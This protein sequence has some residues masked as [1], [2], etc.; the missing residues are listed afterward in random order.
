MGNGFRLGWS[1]S[2]ASRRAGRAGARARVERGVE[3][4]NVRPSFALWVVSVPEV[5]PEAKLRDERAGPGQIHDDTTP[6]PFIKH[7]F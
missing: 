5:V 1:A 6:P 7:E 4:K 3:Q 2:S